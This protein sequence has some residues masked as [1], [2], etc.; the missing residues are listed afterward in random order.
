LGGAEEDGEDSNEHFFWVQIVHFLL[1]IE[2]VFNKEA[3]KVE[4]SC[5]NSVDHAL[6]KSKCKTSFDMV[7][8]VLLANGLEV[9]AVF[10]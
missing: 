1:F 3:T 5:K 2:V 10:L 4:K 7:L 9:F 6:R 8:L